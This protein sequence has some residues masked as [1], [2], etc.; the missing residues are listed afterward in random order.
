MK[1]IC[2]ARALKTL[3]R[4]R[5]ADLHFASRHTQMVFVSCFAFVFVFK[6][7]ETTSFLYSIII[8]KQNKT[9]QNKN[10]K[11]FFH[12]EARAFSSNTRI[13]SSPSET[14]IAP[15]ASHAPLPS[16]AVTSARTAAPR[17]MG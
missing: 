8:T 12:D 11:L 15:A 5:R 10:K 7:K 14:L 16:S 13:S 2:D 17:A 1:V 6:V 4:W 3:C 9:K